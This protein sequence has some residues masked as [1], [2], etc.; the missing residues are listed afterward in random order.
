MP[1]TGSS[2][3]RQFACCSLI[4]LAPTVAAASAVSVSPPI[5]EPGERLTILFWV[6]G[7]RFARAS[8]LEEVRCTMDTP[9]G[10]TLDCDA[11]AT[12]V[13]LQLQGGRR[14]YSFTL[15]APDE[16]GAYAVHV[17]RVATLE[18]SVPPGPGEAADGAFEVAL[19]EQPV[20]PNDGGEPIAPHEAPRDTGAGGWLASLFLG[21]GSTIAAVLLTR[22]GG[23]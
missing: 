9:S 20:P 7:E 3:A 22:Q 12:L 19:P 18:L 11:V 21:T 5:A 16:P 17:A 1:N 10:A 23:A 2:R 8:V 6:E 13:D 14:S 15:Q 4:L